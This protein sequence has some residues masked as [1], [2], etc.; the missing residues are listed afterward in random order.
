MKILILSQYW[1]P[2][3]GVPQR[4]W[5]WLSKVLI[6]AG[7]EVT[8]I[9]PPP[10]Y[11]RKMDL[12]TWWGQRHFSSAVESATGPSGERIVRSGFLPSGPSLTQRAMNQ[13]TVALGAVWVI[14]KRPGKLKG[15][16]PDLVIGT[17]PALPTAVATRFAARKFQAPYIVDLRDA[18]PDL[19]LESEKWNRGTGK[20]SLREK[21]LSKGPFQVVSG[22]T[23]AALNNAL[24]GAA[25]ISVTSS[26][27]AA[28]L[29]KRTEIMRDGSTPTIVTV[30]NVFPPESTDLRP[31]EDAGSAGQ[32]RV[33]YAGTFGRAQNL[34][35]ALA[36]A[37]LAKEQGIDIS[38][39][40]VGAGVAREALVE[41]VRRRGIDASIESRKPAEELAPY[42]AWAD[43]AL[44]HLTDWEPLNRAVPSKTYELM[45][46][47]IHISAVVDGETAELVRERNAGIVV[48][49]EDPKALADQ[50][51]NLAQ[52]R[53]L[54]RTEGDGPHWVRT[55]R[56]TVAPQCLLAL[57]EEAGTKKR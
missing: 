2:E 47:Q 13:G 17:V 5:S 8:V 32:L 40:L 39:C 41:S 14:L 28:D 44:V 12:K 56:E 25:G 34:E 51:V 42:Y 35:N 21:V 15:Y 22:L 31:R 16:R 3:N 54:L 6:D 20:K 9:A 30:R 23:K 43:T 27:L 33:L 52:N 36:A 7:H 57:V 49:P 38:L 4:R 46:A 37:E 26:H 18:W 29:R 55:E 24:K 50:W 10:H 19:L 53:Q 48:A 11:Q 45:A 1:Y